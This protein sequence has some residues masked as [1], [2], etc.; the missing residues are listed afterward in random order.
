MKSPDFTSTASAVW[1]PYPLFSLPVSC[2]I[3]LILLVSILVGR[4][5]RY[6]IRSAPR[7]FDSSA[8]CCYV[9]LLLSNI[10]NVCNRMYFIDLTCCASANCRLYG[11]DRVRH[12]LHLSPAVGLLL[13]TQTAEVGSGNMDP[14]QQLSDQFSLSGDSLC[15]GHRTIRGGGDSP[16]HQHGAAAGRGAVGW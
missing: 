10:Y 5:P 15:H 6:S 4:F 13:E 16:A 7:L 14:V 11:P 2:L 1:R 3:S 8:L 12:L 9:I